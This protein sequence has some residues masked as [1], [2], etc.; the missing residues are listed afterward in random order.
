[1]RIDPH[2]N[3]M[4]YKVEKMK[5]PEFN[6]SGMKQITNTGFKTFDRQNNLVTTGNV[7]SNCQTSFY[8]DDHAIKTMPKHWQGVNSEFLQKIANLS[9]KV[10]FYEFFV[11]YGGKKSVFYQAAVNNTT[12]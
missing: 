3:I 9:D 2:L 4:R 7:L 8:L 11:R 12:G 6:K 5:R 10:I 1:M